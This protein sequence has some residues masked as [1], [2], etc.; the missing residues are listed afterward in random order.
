MTILICVMITAVLLAAVFNPFS[1]WIDH[2]DKTELIETS[3]EIF[4][5]D[6]GPY[7]IYAFKITDDGFQNDSVFSSFY[8]DQASLA[9]IEINLVSYN[10]GPISQEGLTA[11]RTLFE[12]LS[13]SDHQWIVRFLYDWDGE[14][15]KY[16]PLDLS[17]ILSHID[18]LSDMLHQFAE[19]I[20]ILQ[21]FLIGNWGEMNGSRFTSIQNLSKIAEH[22]LKAADENTYLAVRT[23]VQL[24]SLKEAGI[25][26]SRIGL[27]NDGL[28]GSESDLGTYGD[29]DGSQDTT[30]WRRELELAYQDTICRNTPNGGE[31]VGTSRYS[32]FENALEQMK[33]IHIA[34]LNADYDPDT[35]DKWRNTI[36]K[37]GSAFE[38]MNAYDYMMRHIGY[39]YV[40]VEASIQQSKTHNNLSVAVKLKNE[41]FAPCF[42]KPSAAVVLTNTDGQTYSF[43]L[44]G[45]FTSLCFGDE[46]VQ[47]STE[48][49]LASLPHENY[50]ATLEIHDEEGNLLETANQQTEGSVEF[51]EIIAK[52]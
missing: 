4:R 32:D 16:E 39:R 18:A 23:P 34:Y 51:A 26:T 2:I 15:W 21:G 20:I 37:D 33:T 14:A 48:I 41:G 17:I 28:L 22:L 5:N 49:A 35:L 46:S 47:L 25:D 19:N 24:R 6:C 31:V 40:F 38:G 8:H 50:R 13:Q 42:K 29:H 1:S 36:V 52:Q 11:I 3:G 12:K 10:T 30:A 45:D 43:P 9:L 27:F 44:Q 7:H